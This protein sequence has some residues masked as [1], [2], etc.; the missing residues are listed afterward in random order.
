MVEST[1]WDTFNLSE[2]P[3]CASFGISGLYNP[4]PLSQTSFQKTLAL[5]DDCDDLK[6]RPLK[7]TKQGL[8]LVACGTDETQAL[9]NQS[10]EYADEIK[11]EIHYDP[12]FWVEERNHYSILLDLSDNKSALFRRVLNLFPL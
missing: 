7:T 5:P 9:K 3:L 10:R 11:R 12:M 8:D 6:A 2:S 4:Q 1:N